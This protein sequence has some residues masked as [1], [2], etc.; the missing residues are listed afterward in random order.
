MASGNGHWPRGHARN[1]ITRSNNRRESDHLPDLLCGDDPL[2]ISPRKLT[3]ILS[4]FGPSAR[5]LECIESPTTRS[6]R[7]EPGRGW[8]D[9]A[10]TPTPT[11]TKGQG[12]PGEFL[13]L[14]K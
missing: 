1:S 10:L 11:I 7:I 4:I 13:N 6:G 3:G 2:N 14:T 9:G 5:S 12:P 8:K